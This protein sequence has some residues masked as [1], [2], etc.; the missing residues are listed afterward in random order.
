MILTY[1]EI[2][3]V[4][5]VFVI[6]AIVLH[7]DVYVCFYFISYASL[8]LLMIYINVSVIVIVVGSYTCTH[9]HGCIIHIL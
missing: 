2:K 6:S 7:G 1:I 9:I 4:C 3:I 8:C 5:V